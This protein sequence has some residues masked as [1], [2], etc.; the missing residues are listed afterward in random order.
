MTR[1]VAI[2]GDDTVNDP[3]DE[4]RQIQV[5]APCYQIVEL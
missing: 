3:G 5:K 4:I 2:F 1:P